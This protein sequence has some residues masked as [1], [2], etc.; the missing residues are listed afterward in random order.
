M[1]FCLKK[2]FLF[3]MSCLIC[4]GCFSCA[5]TRGN[6][7]TLNHQPP[8]G[9]L[10]NSDILEQLTQLENTQHQLMTDLESSKEQIGHLTRKVSI[11]EAQVQG[12]SEK[13]LASSASIP[14]QKPLNDPENLYQQA[15]NLLMEKKF[16]EAIEIFQSF[17]DTYP[18]NELADNTMYWMGECYYSMGHF[19]KAIVIF[20]DLVSRYPKGIKVPDALLKTG[21]SYISLKDFNRANHFL[22]LVITRY[23]F[24][25][26]ADKAQKKL[27]TFN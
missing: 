18:D 21:Y 16:P 2:P 1:T 24:S 27:D 9:A 20:Q 3:I 17:I 19:N 22:K 10:H 11:I 14:D 15:R 13:P 26:A 4:L 6:S 5:S 8:S 12:L 23:P 25:D 7:D